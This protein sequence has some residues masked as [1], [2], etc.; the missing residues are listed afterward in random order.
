MKKKK[1]LIT[2]GSTIVPIDKVRVISNIF[3]GKT[4]TAIAEHFAN[5]GEEVTLITS[6]PE[7]VKMETKK[8]KVITFKTFGDLAKYMEKEITSGKYDLIIHSAAVS[9]Y[10]VSGVYLRG[11]RD[12]MEPL[13]NARKVSSRHEEVYIKLVP[14]VKLV[15]LIKKLWGFKGK[16]VK[17]KLEVGIT[18]E[19]LIEIA[20]KSMAASEADMMVANCLEWSAIYA[21]II[22]DAGKVEKVSRRKLAEKLGRRL[23]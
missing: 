17:F 19:E 3:K 22:D 12:K 8:M 7:L 5:L 13:D 9:D 2:A 21:Y 18:D 15:D 11:E 10:S 14:T 20:K 16:L 23:L 4:G 1:I 6:S